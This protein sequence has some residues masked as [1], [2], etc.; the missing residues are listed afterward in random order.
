MK[1]I[2]IHGYGSSDVLQFEDVSRPQAD[3]D[4]VLVK[5]YDAGLNPVDWKIREGFLK[6]SSPRTFPFTAGQDFAGE[7]VETGER[8]AQFTGGDAVFGFAKGAYAEYA[9]ARADEIAL[10]PKSIDFVTAAAIPTAGLTA[11]QAIVDAARISQ[12]QSVLIHG[13]AGGV[14]SFAVQIAKWKGAR[15]IATASRTD[16]PYLK[17]LGADEVIDY[18]AER[19]EAKTRDLDAVIDLVGGE[20]L[21]RSYGLLKKGGVVVTTLGYID[22]SKLQQNGLKGVALF[23]K[24]DGMEL[25]E[26]G[27]LVEQGIVTP[28]IDQVLPISEAKKAQEMSQSGKAHGKIVLRVA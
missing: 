10:K 26:L 19:F 14:G 11:W 6:D 22:E 8:V 20:T 27:K 17:E 12:G 18:K 15:L 25:A 1:A 7:V 23:M 21:A 2:R 28:R 4:E 9:A 16:I 3:P 5:T 24:R 13:A